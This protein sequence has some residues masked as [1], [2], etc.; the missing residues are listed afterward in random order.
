[1]AAAADGRRNPLRL[2]DDRARGGLVRRHQH[3]NPHRAR[4]RSLRHQRPQM[5]V[6]GR[7]R[8][9]LQDRHRDG[10]DRSE[11]AAPPAAV[12]DPGA[13]R[14]QGHQGREAAAGVRLRR[15]A[16]RPRPGAAGERARS[17]QQHPAR[18]GQGLRDR[19]GPSR[20]RP[21]PSLHAHHRQG[22]GSAG[23]DGE[24]AVLAHRVRQEDHRILDLG[25]A[26]RRSPHR[27]RDEPAVV[28]EGRRHDG[29]GRQQ[30][31][32]ARDRHDQG[33]GA[34]HGAEDHR[35]RDPGVRRR[36]RLRRCGLARDYAS[37]RTMRLADGPDEVHNR[38]IARLEL[39]KYANA[40]TTH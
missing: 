17:R 8:S 23:E 34:Q 19:A 11:G 6:V 35:P 3:R 10:Q 5:V 28:P 26:H 20:S 27:H 39:R 14:H 18:R 1:M 22:R 15:R 37:M 13:A 33:G 16:A 29:Q 30:D 12:A 21:H 9:A 7:R 32:A 24:A 40:P 25:A 4:R 2:P 31:R 36:R 38:A